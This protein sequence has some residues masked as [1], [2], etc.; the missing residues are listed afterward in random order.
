MGWG[1]ADH[2]SYPARLEALYAQQSSTVEVINGAQPGHSSFQGVWLYAS[3]LKHYEPDVVLIDYVVQDAR[4]VPC[5]DRHQ[6]IL[7]SSE[8][9]L[10]HQWLYS[11]ATEA[12]LGQIL[13]AIPE[14]ACES[15]Q[16]CPSLRAP[17]RDYASNLVS[18]IDQVR[19]SGATPILHGF[20]LE[21]SGYTTDHRAVLRGVARVMDVRLIDVQPD[22]EAHARSARVE[23]DAPLYFRRDPGHATA[24]GHQWIAE[25]VHQSLG[26]DPKSPLR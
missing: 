13:Q 2:E 19:E 11:V 5:S 7:Q 9:Y 20:P 21:V 25:R 26:T 3:L 10:E 8:E 23:Q 14:R 24:A 16:D 4:E 1:L 12:Q 18:I 15:D 22:M 6:A 17:L